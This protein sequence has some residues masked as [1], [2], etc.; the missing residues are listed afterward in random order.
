MTTLEAVQLGIP[1]WLVLALPDDVAQEV[2]LY[3]HE[4]PGARGNALR[5][6]LRLRMRSLRHQVW[7]REPT[8]Q[9]RHSR[10]PRPA[11]S[12][13]RRSEIGRLGRQKQLE[14]QRRAIARGEWKLTEAQY[15]AVLKAAAARRKH[16]K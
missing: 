8:P 7:D 16:G 14:N 12:A 2:E 5:A 11:V 13:E 4:H 15:A 3:R 10:A 9:P 1:R 6:G